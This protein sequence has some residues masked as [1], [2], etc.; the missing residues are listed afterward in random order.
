M[1]KTADELNAYDP[2]DD[3]ERDTDITPIAA[4]MDDSDDDNGDNDDEDTNEEVEEIRAE[5]EQTRAEMTDT[6][7]A[8]QERLSPQHLM[9]QAKDTVREATIGRV[10]HMVS[11]VGDKI[12]E[13]AEQTTSG[14]T[15]QA[16]GV[17]RLVRENPVPAAIAGLGLGWLFMKGRDSDQRRR[18]TVYPT[19]VYPRYDTYPP[20][21][22]GRYGGSTPR[23]ERSTLDSGGE[24]MGDARE[25]V[26]EIAGEAADRA[27][28]VV[29]Q[30]Q[31]KAGDL[32][33]TIKQNPIPAAMA[34]LGL[35]F[36]FNGGNSSSQRQTRYQDRGYGGYQ[37]YS[38][39]SGYQDRGY[40]GQSSASDRSVGDTISDA[41][42]KVGDVA[43]EARDRV[44]E[45]AG[46]ARERVGDV[47]SQVG[48]TVGQ[49]ASQVGSTAGQVAGTAGDTAG[50]IFGMIRRNPVPAAL[51]GLSIAWLVMNR[52]D[53]SRGEEMLYQARH[54]VGDTVGQAGEK[55][56]D[57]ASQAQE[58]AG[59]MAVRAQGQFQQTLWD[60]PLVV[61]AAAMA[62]GAAIGLAVPETPQEHQLMGQARDNLMQ[63]A[64]GMAQDTIER[65]QHVAERVTERVTEEAQRTVQT[66][67]ENQGLTQTGGSA[68]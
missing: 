4:R 53:G 61:G 27:G 14:V 25:R 21:S 6:I 51:A 3:H 28:E 58:R 34:G 60:N 56:A 5:I 18:S 8:I 40:Q 33:S 63:K 11:N 15:E 46:E 19:R 55:V 64:Q 2:L 22:G 13:V 10:E 49:V 31:D 67:A 16:G 1:G 65:V 36:L 23:N 37:G 62:L 35:W 17:L 68:G 47:A 57:T 41:R 20:Y 45:V 7:N 32:L 30:A 38:G 52:E 59:V 42:D 9:E 44:G 29:S 24:A 54:A 66:E 26:G 43:S 39:Y 12:G 48:D 50:D